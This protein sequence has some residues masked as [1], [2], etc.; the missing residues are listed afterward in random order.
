MFP[1][2]DED[3]GYVTLEAFLARKPV[4]TTTD[5]GGPLEFV[6]DGVTGLVTVGAGS[7]RRAMRR[8]AATPAAALDRQRRVRTRSRH[9]VG[10]RRSNGW[11]RPIEQDRA[12]TG[13][14]SVVVRRSQRSRVHRSAHR[15]AS[16]PQRP[17]TRSSSSTMDRATRTG[18]RAA[19]AG[20]RVIRH[21]YNKGNGA[22]VKTG[23]AGG[24][25]VSSWTPTDSISPPMPGASSPAS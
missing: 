25:F 17:G 22:A 19:A 2:F 5:A 23:I 13:R 16:Q 21:P 7:A 11:C 14:V 20:A 8:L 4:V 1:P 24:E 3:Y 15:S 18:R 9:H 10:R 12:L 6:E